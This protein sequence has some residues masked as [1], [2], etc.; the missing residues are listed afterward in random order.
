MS[1]AVVILGALGS[2]IFFG[3]LIVACLPSAMVRQ[4]LRRV[5]GAKRKR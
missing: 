4:L 3:G 2:L 1:T 5:S